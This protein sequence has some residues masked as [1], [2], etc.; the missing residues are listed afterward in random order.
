MGKP[1]AR[2]ELQG[3]DLK[4]VVSAAN[5]HQ[6]RRRQINLSQLPV[7]EFRLWPRRA[8]ISDSEY[9]RLVV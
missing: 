7:A 6:L 2:L 4:R 1:D 8:P 9:N 3:V 5:M